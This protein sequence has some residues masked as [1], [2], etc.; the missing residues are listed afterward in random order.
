M[1][2]TQDNKLFNYSLSA[3]ANSRALAGG[4]PKLPRLRA[5]ILSCKIFRIFDSSP[6]ISL[7][8]I[9]AIVFSLSMIIFAITLAKKRKEI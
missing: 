3:N 2:V 7:F 1:I 4:M 9:I 5:L 6:A 8:Y